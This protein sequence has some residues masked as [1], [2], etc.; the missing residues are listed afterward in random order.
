MP[1]RRPW[2]RLLKLGYIYR[3]S[4]K[5]LRKPFIVE[6]NHNSRFREVLSHIHGGLPANRVKPHNGGYCM[7]KNTKKIMQILH[8]YISRY[9]T[10]WKNL[11]NFD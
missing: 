2:T 11:E 9:G 7:Q 8:K 1:T 6:L 5:Y 4:W 3:A 10:L